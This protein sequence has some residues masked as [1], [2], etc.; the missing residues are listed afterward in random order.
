MRIKQDSAGGPGETPVFQR[1]LVALAL[2]PHLPAVLNHSC[3]ILKPLG[4]EAVFLHVG[5]NTAAARQ[6]LGAAIAASAFSGGPEPRLII[7]PGQPVEVIAATARSEHADLIVAGAPKKESLLRHFLGSVA[8]QLAAVT[9]CSLLLM[10]DPAVTPE[11]IFRVHCAVEY[12]RPAHFAVR[13]AI[14]LARYLHSRELVLTHSFRAPEWE[15]TPPQGAMTETRRYYHRQDLRLKRFLSRF[16]SQGV[17]CRAQCFQEQTV[18][19]TLA[20]ARDVNANLL[21]LP[22][23]RRQNGVWDR[24]LKNNLNN[25]LQ[26]LPEAILLTRKPR[27]RVHRPSAPPAGD[28]KKPVSVLRKQA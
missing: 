4:A 19:S 2:S 15:K 23:S 7:Q 22:S 5:P 25:L 1:A 6:R 28:K 13:V 26:A 8:A 10:T 21:V 18:N 11:P 20:F 9:P 24:L 16:P 12:D 14:T 27:Y 17:S 3:H